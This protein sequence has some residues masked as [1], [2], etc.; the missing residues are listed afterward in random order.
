MHTILIFQKDTKVVFLAACGDEP[1]L[2][3]G[4]VVSKSV[5]FDEVNA[6]TF[7][8]SST[9]GESPD[10]DLEIAISGKIPGI[11]RMTHV[12]SSW[13]KGMRDTLYIYLSELVLHVYISFHVG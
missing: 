2:K 6:L 12:S 9:R 5:C 10:S 1:F 8:D 3:T 7:F 13:G 4:F 11:T